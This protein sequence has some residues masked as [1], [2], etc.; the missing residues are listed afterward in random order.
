[1]K[2]QSLVLSVLTTGMLFVSFLA[3]MQPSEAKKPPN[4][5]PKNKYPQEV[6][7]NFL[8]GC[9]SQAVSGGTLSEADAQKFCNC[10]IQKFQ[11]K[12]TLEQFM[13]LANTLTTDSNSMNKFNEVVNSCAQEVVNRRQ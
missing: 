3:N 11:A 4:S 7:G 1:M 13:T 5:S 12:Y 10:S 9:V 6:V 8:K 2:S